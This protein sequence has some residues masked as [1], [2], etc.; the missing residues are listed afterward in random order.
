MKSPVLEL[1]E[2]TLY[3]SAGWRSFCELDAPAGVR[4]ADLD[5]ASHLVLSLDLGAGWALSYAAGTLPLDAR[6]D[7]TF[8]LGFR[9]QF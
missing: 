9:V 7:S 5:R 3:L 4:R 1:D 8:A 6:Y 2:R